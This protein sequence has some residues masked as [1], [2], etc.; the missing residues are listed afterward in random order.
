MGD[1]ASSGNHRRVAPSQFLDVVDG[2]PVISSAAIA[3][4][5]DKPH[6]SVIRLIRNS[7]ADLEEFGGVGFE[8]SP[9]ETAGGKQLRE[10]AF[11][12]EQQTTVLFTFMRNNPVVRQ[13]KKCLVKEFFRLRSETHVPS[14]YAGALRLAADSV[15]K[16][17]LLEA[18]NQRLLETLEE[19][20]TKVLQHDILA[21]N[22]EDYSVRDAA[23]ILGTGQNKL[24]A[25]LRS[26]GWVDRKNKPYQRLVTAGLLKVSL[27]EFNHPHLGRISKPVPRVTSKGL[28]GLTRLVCT[29]VS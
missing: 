29:D 15:D 6:A 20:Q 7:R 24:M 11:L 8:I 1:L 5:V 9:L 26:L 25:K 27:S 14:N 21:A 10:V 23:Q 17:D 3:E 16:C 4:G 13:F 22:S 28:L 18:Q 12:N 19:A 2:N